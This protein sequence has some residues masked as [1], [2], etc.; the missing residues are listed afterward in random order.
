MKHGQTPTQTGISLS[1]GEMTALLSALKSAQPGEADIYCFTDQCPAMTKDVGRY[2]FRESVPRLKQFLSLVKQPIPG[3]GEPRR[4]EIVTYLENVYDKASKPEETLNWELALTGFSVLIF[5]PMVAIGWLGHK[6]SQKL[7]EI[8][9]KQL[10]EKPPELKDFTKDLVEIALKQIA[11]GT[12]KPIRGRDKEALEFLRAIA[13]NKRGNPLLVGE[14]GV[15]KDVVVLRAAQMIA[16]GDPR[17]PKS[18]L[19]KNA[20][21]LLTVDGVALQSGT[22]YRGT[23]ADRMKV[24]KEAM[25]AGHIPY[26][27]E[28]ADLM[29]AGSAEG[30]S[31]EALGA[32]LKPVIDGSQAAGE[33]GLRL[34]AI[35][36][37][38]T[39]ANLRKLLLDPVFRDLYRRTA[40]IPV[41]E[42][43][44]A[45]VQDVIIH[46]SIP[47]ILKSIAKEYSVQVEF[48][49]DALEAIFD[50]GVKYIDH[51]ARNNNASRSL[52]DGLESLL[53]QVVES[54]VFP[55]GETQ[56]PETRI[57]IT[58]DHVRSYLESLQHLGNGDSPDILRDM[59]DA[60]RALLQA[61][62][63]EAMKD[64]AFVERYVRG[65]RMSE[66]GL[67]EVMLRASEPVRPM[68]AGGRTER[69]A[70]RDEASKKSGRRRRPAVEG[71]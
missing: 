35:S 64:P 10:N 66:E 6:Q 70:E 40:Q 63:R 65:D 58:R 50:D 37:S 62:M 38:T 29:A 57:Q 42:L 17:V 5:V 32:M 43:P 18:F 13:R 25:L 9:E 19:G 28:F 51:V 11:D 24:I 48:M 68:A 33:E 16:L 41:K 52:I 39:P 67:Y 27:S 31:S 44:M 12:L 60:D 53:T 15:G 34:P 61:H 55:D 59:S 7:A 45:E 4:E 20:R 36:G 47:S 1:V 8:Q 69:G 54:R 49:S 21:K 14:S 23:S 71:K 22:K 3:I 30:S 2:Y 46:S 56:T 26:L